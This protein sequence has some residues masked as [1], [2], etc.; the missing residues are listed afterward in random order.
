MAGQH[1][2][3]PVAERLRAGG[4]RLVEPAQNPG[5]LGYEQVVGDDLVQ[6]EP[7]TAGGPA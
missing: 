6:L 1:V 2:T 4:G 5:R 7:G 3:A